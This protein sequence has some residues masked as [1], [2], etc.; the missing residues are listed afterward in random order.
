MKKLIGILA[1]LAFVGNVANAELLKNFKY[2]GK[3]EVNGVSTNNESDADSDAK[4]KTSDVDVRVQV[5][6]SFDLADDVN[7]VVSAVKCN[8]QYGDASDTV[9]NG[10][11]GVATFEQ[12]YLNLKGVLGFDHK[13]GRQYY[14]NEGDLAVYYGPRSWPYA[15]KG[16]TNNLGVSG[17]DA[18]TGW[19]KNG[20]LDIHGV[21]AKLTVPALSQPDDDQ[22]LIGVAAKYDLMDELKIGAYVYERKTWQTAAADLTLD[23]VGVK[24]MGKFM[25]FDYNA[26]LVKNYGRQAVGKTY[27]GTAFLANA[28]YDLEA[29]G[30]WTFMGE[31]GMGSGDDKTYAADKDINT[32]NQISTDYRPGIIY[33]GV[34][35]NT[36]LGN[37]TTWNLGAKWNP[38][39]IEKLTLTGKL[40]YFAP[41]VTK[42]NSTAAGAAK[43]DIGYDAYGK[44][45]DLCANWQHNDSVG[46]KAYYAMYMVDGDYADTV[47]AG[48]DDLATALGAA[49]TVKF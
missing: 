48:K 15:T 23:M 26:E 5:N 14:G 46:L 43:T 39:N 44:E 22:D 7:A 19:Y 40:H 10:T 41:T 8:R 4:D 27:T 6:A 21:A 1:V 42:V 37:L 32:F 25:G 36:G 2:D 20:K 35:A 29:M 49:F 3:I 45:L 16:T 47:L 31:F 30:K 9:Q 28:K 38:A 17:I 34:S 13:V 12:A 11:I 33:G 24:A 18:Y